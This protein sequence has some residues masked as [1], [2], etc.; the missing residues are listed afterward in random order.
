MDQ[1]NKLLIDRFLKL[2]REVEPHIQNGRAKNRSHLQAYLYFS[3][4]PLFSY[5]ESIIILCENGKFQAAGSLL[6]SLVELHINAIYYQVADSDYRLAVSVKRM[7]EQKI[8]GIRE[9]KQLIQKYPNIQSSDPNHLFSIE[10]LDN[11]EEWAK[12]EKQA[13]LKGNSL[14]N[15]D[16]ELALKDKAIKCDQAHIKNTENGH[17]ERIYHVIYR[18]L[19]SATHLDIG[20][21]QNFVDQDGDGKYIFSDGDYKKYYMM[22][23]AISI[24]V[25]LTKDLY[26]NDVIE[27][28]LPDSVFELEECLN[29][30]PKDG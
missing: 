2:K 20:G 28:A 15:D 30:R 16:P 18:Q 26:E 7:F 3:C 5:V 4:Y 19:S 12:K 13:V 29:I 22:Q 10:W 25:A 27:S 1:N 24:C 14:K 23:E 6:R 9:L 11:A 8:K 21:L 17:F